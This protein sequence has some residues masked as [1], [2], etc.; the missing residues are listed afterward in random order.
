M[1]L[2]I[3]AAVAVGVLLIGLFAW[4][5]AQPAD[6]F[7]PVLFIAGNI[8][9]DGAFKLAGLAVLASL[10]AFFVSWPYGRHIAVLAVPSGLAVWAIRSG[11]MAELMRQNPAAT[12]RLDLFAQIK[13]EPFSWLAIIGLGFLAVHICTKF[14]SPKTA[15]DLRARSVPAKAYFI[16]FAVALGISVLLA[17]VLLLVLA[18]DIKVSDDTLGAVIVQVTTAQAVF[19]ILVSFGAVAFVIKKFLD[20]GYTCPV[21]AAALVHPA[22]IGVY[23][24]PEV[25]EYMVNRWPAVFYPNSIV[26][27]LPIQMVAFGTLGSIAGYWMAVRYDYWRKHES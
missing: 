20:I 19:A 16:N 26:A 14:L 24:K 4:P 13:W 10:L 25:M 21:I 2:R 27:I 1:R 23:I 17:K 8:T 11:D 7:D 3:T 15:S 12:E 22:V 9:R 6:P 5:I 18:Q